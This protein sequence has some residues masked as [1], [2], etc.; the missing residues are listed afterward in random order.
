MIISKVIVN[1]IFYKLHQML[2]LMDTHTLNCA[3]VLNFCYWAFL[4]YVGLWY[5]KNIVIAQ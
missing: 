1:I 3:L 5:G 4:F 2:S